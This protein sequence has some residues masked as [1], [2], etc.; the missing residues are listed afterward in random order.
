MATHEDSEE[1]VKSQSDHFNLDSLKTHFEAVIS[2]DGLVMLDPYILGYEELDKFIHLLGTVFGW[3]ASDLEAKLDILRGKRRNAKIS[4]HF[5]DVHSMVKQEVQEKLIMFKDRD[6]STGTRNL[7]RLHR[8]LE[9]IV[10]F[11]ESLGQLENSDKCVGIAQDAY[12]SSL[13]KYHPWIV[14]KAALL[15]MHILPTKEGLIL[16]VCGDN[17]EKQD[18]AVHTFNQA[19]KAMK[20]VYEK[21]ED[22]YRQYNLLDLP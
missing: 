13:N 10:I 17:P 22:I 8:A 5:E 18:R 15:A 4:E 3:V 9:F 2:K 20:A 11:M 21:T 1:L 16:K 19:I 7:L 12:K 14:Q 6:D